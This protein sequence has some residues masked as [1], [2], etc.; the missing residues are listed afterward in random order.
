LR[1]RRAAGRAAQVRRR[2]PRLRDLGVDRIHLRPLGSLLDGEAAIHETSGATPRGRERFRILDGARRL[3][4]SAFVECPACQR[5]LVPRPG[6]DGRFKSWC[7][8]EGCGAALL[9]EV[10]K[11]VLAVQGPRAL[12]EAELQNHLEGPTSTTALSS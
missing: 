6:N 4:M 12:H 1:I 9:C 5:K 8:Y 7:P 10:E 2:R 11:G 3:S